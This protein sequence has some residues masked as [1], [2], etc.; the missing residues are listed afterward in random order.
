MISNKLIHLIHN[1]DVIHWIILDVDYRLC[2]SWITSIS[3]QLWGYKVEKKLYTWG[4]CEQK[5]L[6]TTAI[7]DAMI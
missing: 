2:V 1:L 3:Q 6:N 4:V 7:S 5:S